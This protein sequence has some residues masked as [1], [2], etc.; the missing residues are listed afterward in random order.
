MKALAFL[1]VSVLFPAAVLGQAAA[2]DAPRLMFSK[3]FPGSVPPYFAIAIAPDGT[4]TY[5][6][7]E[8]PDYAEE[9]HLEPAA[10]RQVFELAD[11]LDHFKRPVES[12]LKI[13]NMGQKT[14]RWELGGEVSEA[15][16]NYSTI[17]DVK[18]LADIFERI[19][20]SE[21]MILDL[22]RVLKHDRLGVNDAVLRI[23]AAWENKRLLLSA[24][25]L[26]LLDQV[27]MND[28][29]IHMARERAARMADAIRA[30]R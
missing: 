17:D 22:R 28:A 26:P 9:A 11:H 27:A 16:Y 20:D 7:S 23:Q 2:T 29:Y 8:D 18:A 30:S 10:A 25:V 1:A 12:G 24:D 3:S 21:R 13:A 14:F 4:A 15:K 5:N 19:A 6:E